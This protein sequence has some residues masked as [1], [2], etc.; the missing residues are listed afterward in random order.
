MAGFWAAMIELS[1]DG[2]GSP[3][4]GATL[5]IWHGMEGR[6]WWLQR[7]VDP[8]WHVLRNRMIDMILF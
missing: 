1:E 5:A 3:W 2:G 7:D 6:G 4:S 8:W